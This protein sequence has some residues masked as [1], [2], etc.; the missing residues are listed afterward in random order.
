MHLNKLERNILIK[1]FQI[2][3]IQLL[4]QHDFNKIKVTKRLSTEVGFITYIEKME[5]LK[6]VKQ[7]KSFK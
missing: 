4:N 5:L 1:F 7:T 6:I 2:E 3:K